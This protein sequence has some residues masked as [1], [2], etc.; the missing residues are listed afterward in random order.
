MARIPQAEV[1]RLKDEVAVQRLV[2]SAGIELN[3]VGKDLAGKCP[4]HDDREPS[5]I[6]TPTKNL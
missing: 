3:R 5:L 6:V 1:Q 4:F 2:E